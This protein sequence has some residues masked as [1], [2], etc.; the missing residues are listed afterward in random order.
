[1]KPINL[2]KLLQTVFFCLP[3]WLTAE[4]V[5]FVLGSAVSLNG[6]PQMLL[7]CRQDEAFPLL[8]VVKLPLS[9][10]VLDRVD[11]NELNL[12]QRFDLPAEKL[13]ANTWSP[14]LKEHPEGGSFTLRE[15]LTY[16]IAKSDNN[17]CDVLFQLV[18]GPSTV[19]DF[20]RER[21]GRDFA[22]TIVCG[23][24]AFRDNPD[25]MRSNT[26][27]PRA[28]I[29]LLNDLY[30]AAHP[31]A[32]QPA[33]PLLSATAAKLLLRI[34]TQTHTGADRLA[35]ACPPEAELA[36]KTGSSGTHCGFT[37]AFNDVGIL[38]LPGGSYAAIVCF[39]RDSRV[40]AD[41]MC[42]QHRELCRKAVLLLKA[43]EP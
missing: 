15:L 3:M 2:I 9:V 8:S 7:T 21:Y 30:A 29:T 39:L 31:A 24:D 17:A 42:R 28:V 38:M 33:T 5:D 18:G 22:L 26:A 32:N 27:S 35:A 20:F 40:N 34:M 11:K 12:E 13:D 4:E 36:H 14:L 19:Q 16:C 23:E 10:V 41:T 6:S 37:M 43:Q 1:M 25:N